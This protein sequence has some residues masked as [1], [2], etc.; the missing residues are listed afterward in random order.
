MAGARGHHP[1]LSYLP[2]DDLYELNSAGFKFPDLGR[3]KFPVAGQL[4]LLT[5][6]GSAFADFYCANLIGTVTISAKQFSATDYFRWA[7]DASPAA[8]VA[9]TATVWAEDNGSGKTRL[10]C[11]FGTGANQQIAIEP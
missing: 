1:H 4:Q 7:E 5:A 3:L 11:V 9:N 8:G 10:M 6:D 2:T